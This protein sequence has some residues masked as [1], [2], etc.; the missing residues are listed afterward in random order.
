MGYELLCSRVK[1]WPQRYSDQD[2]S[3]AKP[4]QTIIF[5]P[6]RRRV[7]PC[8]FL[9]G[10][11]RR[12]SEGIL[13]S[14]TDCSAYL[15]GSHPVWPERGWPYRPADR[16]NSI[17]LLLNSKSLDQ[18]WTHCNVRSEGID[19]CVHA[20]HH[21][22]GESEKTRSDSRTYL[23]PAESRHQLQTAVGL[24]RHLRFFTW[25]RHMLVWP[26]CWEMIFY[27]SA[28]WYW[29]ELWVI[30]NPRLGRIWAFSALTCRKHL[31]TTWRLLFDPAKGWKY[32]SLFEERDTTTIY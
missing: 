17:Y 24:H 11:W 4:I 28:A 7:W 21:V 1:A 12:L 13:S 9:E 25:H 26:V 2:L 19:K 32:P 6:T 27:T 3:H 10:R 15:W 5:S 18:R 22:L 14:H 16:H 31:K 29:K 30:F 20:V 8:L 23:S